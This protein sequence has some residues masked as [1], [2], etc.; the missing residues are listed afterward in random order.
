MSGHNKWSTIKRKKGATDA[1]RGKVFTRLAKEITM[2]ARESGGDPNMNF[3]LRLA[4]DKARS[5]NMPKDSIDR[6]I[7]RG[8][9][10]G[11][12]AETFEEITYEGYAPKGVAL[13]IE[14]VTENRN[15]TIADLRHTLSHFGGNMAD[16]GSVAWQFTRISF[17]ELDANKADFDKVFEIAAEA[18]AEDVDSDGESIEIIAPVEHFKSI[19]NALSD[20]KLEMEEAGIRFQP[21]QE[22]ELTPEETMQVMRCIE[23][24]E[25]L[26]DVQ[27]V[28]S[29]MSIS[30]EVLSTLDE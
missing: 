11:K 8:I 12:D 13:M 10:V 28:F 15:R 1:K 25:E 16:M 23:G 22:M 30:D 9:G 4:L 19:S 24:I 21:N 27:N 17:F 5:N 29:N 3:R 18:G 20:A 14:C 2:A 6:A 7:N 26:D